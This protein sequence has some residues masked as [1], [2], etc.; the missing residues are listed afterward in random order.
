MYLTFDVG[1]TS[2]KVVLYERDG[3]CIDKVIRNYSLESP[4]VNWYE[5]DPEIYWGAVADGVRE[6]CARKRIG[7]GSISS[8]S[9]CSQGETVIFLDDTD[10]PV[11]PAIVWLDLRA[12]AEVEELSRIISNDELYRVTGLSE[13][14]PTWTAAK[15]LWVKHNQPELFTRTAKFLLVEDYVTYR[16]TGRYRR[17]HKS[18]KH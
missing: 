6:I 12:R 4:A 10:T 11:R 1:T 2:V 13:I 8:I 3:R 7:P 14:D 5:T 18:T 16:L 9:G 17:Y 15:I